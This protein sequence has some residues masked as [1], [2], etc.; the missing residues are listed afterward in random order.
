MRGAAPLVV[1]G[2]GALGALLLS[3]RRA[4]AAKTPAAIAPP[5]GT[6]VWPVPSWQGRAPAVSDG[7]G[8]RRDGG[9]RKHRGVDIMFKRT[10]RDELVAEFP[11]GTADGAKWHFMPRGVVAVAAADGVVRS[12]GWAPRGNAVVVRH[13]G[14]WATFYAHLAALLIADGDHVKAGQP[15]GLIGA[16]PLDSQALR[17]LHFALWHGGNSEGAIDPEPIMRRWK[18]VEAPHA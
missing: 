12:A 5:P 6:W 11:P 8:S 4:A 9:M 14:T 16:D 1:L 10:R 7:W 13:D 3:G 2:G 15:L 18:V 17:H